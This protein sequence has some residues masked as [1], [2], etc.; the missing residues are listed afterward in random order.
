MTWFDDRKN[1]GEVRHVRIGKADKVVVVVV[2]T[3]IGTTAF[4]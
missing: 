3:G 2:L 4:A 1:Y